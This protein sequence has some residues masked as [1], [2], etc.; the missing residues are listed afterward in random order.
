MRK[1][2][3]LALD[4]GGIRGLLTT[5]LL[6]RLSADPRLAGAF[7]NID[8]IAGTSSG[9]LIALSMAAGRQQGI[10]MPM[11][12]AKLEERF[13]QGV[14]TFGN[15][16]RWWAGGSWLRARY[17]AQAREQTFRDVLG[18][19]ALGELKQKVLIPSFDLDNEGR[20]DGQPDSQKWKPKL[21]HNME[22][23]RQDCNVAAW[24]V[25]MYTTALPVYFPSSDGFIDGGVYA[26][27]PAMCALAQVLDPRYGP[28]PKP[29]IDDITL[30][31]LGSGLNLKSL[32]RDA[33]RWLVFPWPKSTFRP[34]DPLDW[35]FFRWGEPIVDV[36]VDGTVGIAHYECKNILGPHG[37]RRIAPELKPGI[38]IGTDDLKRVRE[39]KEAADEEDLE[40]HIEW[41]A[42]NWKGSDAPRKLRLPDRTSKHL[43]STT[44]LTCMAPIREGF[45]PGLDTRSYATRLRVVMRVLH[46]L[47]QAAREMK[48][49]KAVLDIVD[50][51]RSIHSFQFAIINERHL[52]LAVTFAGA[53]E[54]YMRIIWR[55]LGPLMDLIL[56]NCTD[57]VPSN[58]PEGYDGFVRYIRSVQV[59]SDFFYSQSGLSVDDQ[60]YLAK[61]EQMV[62]EGSQR[63]D[64]D[65]ATEA[66]ESPAK[67]IARV[68]VANPRDVL[69]QSLLLLRILYGLRDFYPQGDPDQQFLNAA[70]LALLG[71]SKELRAFIEEK[72]SASG[73]L[74][75]EIIRAGD[76]VAGSKLAQQ[77][78]DGKVGAQFQ[79][80][81]DVK[82]FLSLLKDAAG[83]SSGKPGVPGAP[84][85]DRRERGP[86]D[87]IQG[88]ILKPY[89]ATG[90][91]G[92]A[93]HPATHGCLLFAR[94]T[95]A[96]EARRFLR[97]WIGNV[98]REATPETL[99]PARKAGEVFKNIAFTLN[100]LRSLG[101]SDTVL[102]MFPKEFRE[103]M[104]SRA[105]LLGDVR[106]NHPEH[107]ELPEWN[108]N[109]PPPD[110]LH[111][112]P[113]TL[114]EIS[115]IRLSTIDVVVQMRVVAPGSTSEWNSEHP[116]WAAVTAF[117]EEAAQY[118]DGHGNPAVYVM[119]RQLMQDDFDSQGKPVNHFGFVEG[120]SQPTTEG[121]GRD[122]VSLGELLL[123]YEN[124]RKDQAFPAPT[125][126]GDAG[127]RLSF[128]GSL[129]DNGTFLVIRK[130]EQDVE[131]FNAFKAAVSSQ[132]AS[133]DEVLAKMMGRHLDG[134]PLVAHGSSGQNPLNDF[135]YRNDA[136]GIKCPFTAHIR[137]ANPR[138][139]G[140][141]RVPRLMR[142]GMSYGP[143][144]KP[145]A[146]DTAPASERGL[147]FMAYNASIAEQFEVIQRW[148][149]GGNSTGVGSEQRDPF[150]GVPDPRGSN[151][152]RFVDKSGSNVQ[153]VDLGSKPF[154][155]LKWG[156]YLFVP[157]ISALHTL[158]NEPVSSK[159]EREQ[160]IVR[161]NAGQ[162]V[163]Q[164]LKTADDWARMYEDTTAVHSGTSA[165]VSAAIRVIDGGVRRTPYGV[166]VT[167]EPLVTKVLN[168]DAAFSVSEYQ[169]RMARSIGQIYLG[170]DGGPEYDRLATVPNRAIQQVTADEAFNEAGKATIASLVNIV[171][172]PQ[173][174]GALAHL[175]DPSPILF[176]VEELADLTLAALS[177]HWFG[178]PDGDTVLAGGRPTSEDTRPRCPFHSFPPSRYIFSSPQPR[179]AVLAM[180]QKFG[181][182]LLDGVRQ[183]VRKHNGGRWRDQLKDQGKLSRA[184]FETLEPDDDAVAAN[185]VGLLE[186]FLPT[187]YGNFLKVINLWTTDESLWRLQQQLRL[188]GRIDYHHARGVLGQPL[189]KAMMQRPVPDLLY[190]TATR[191]VDLG[192]VR[193]AAGERVV[194]SIAAATQDMTS[195]G[196]LSIAP[197]FGGMRSQAVHPTHACP[198][199]EM[200]MG[201]LLGM[202]AALLQ[203]GTLAPAPHPLMLLGDRRPKPVP[204]PGGGAPGGSVAPV[205]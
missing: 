57:Y 166:I 109:T 194:L 113:D 201:V 122:A 167:S 180:G 123:G 177:K 33:K 140:D 50:A 21:F 188:S 46:G 185:L 117:R 80:P 149:S 94:I 103:G 29:G 130:L 127:Q 147:I 49:N 66:L 164:Q 16:R 199:Y 89:K 59:E 170:L 202:M 2:R 64:F 111:E 186:G 17:S 116:L 97:H 19:V 126:T 34:T 82:W 145:G 128:R 52:L 112:I 124:D 88:G 54:P 148:V 9:G 7:D 53:W 55:D 183:F 181:Q 93:R 70:T 150:V 193:I 107:W 134:R 108:E 179:R 198:G 172:R 40:E 114:H 22:G 43:L 92:G 192:G 81:P 197:V 72:V 101:V 8:L 5:R 10:P 132:G 36:I 176:S 137:R 155:T 14:K 56:C 168:D 195:R 31:S 25:A 67:E 45:I 38:I 174:G 163:M 146:I 173:L 160:M 178:I 35:G 162:T 63:I 161:V 90:V 189:M 23:E 6:K 37:Y 96:A 98:S 102:E 139:A 144:V 151:M 74:V 28:R 196:E 18:S 143:H 47:R 1:F 39:L 104:A 30:L 156:M 175:S 26:N 86:D 51:I 58:S 60:R 125:G 129:L 171:N 15:R 3:V 119:S 95:D 118:R 48:S 133:T 153:R 42:A 12:L 61:V 205:R 115:R 13:E 77:I 41:L 20:A 182:E 44:E 87:E 73:A 11:V 142:R 76:V 65:I 157:S 131:A 200:A 24:K 68:A 71:P 204:G 100:G 187:V 75:P 136:D 83:T 78:I 106:G 27:N 165:L 203:A 158:T 99:P 105:G 85:V 141:P 191:D 120:F 190:R 91:D 110:M 79:L 84:G 69:E 62:R 152:F 32:P 4:G 138:T 169:N 154:V 159:L 184:V 135:D 121:K